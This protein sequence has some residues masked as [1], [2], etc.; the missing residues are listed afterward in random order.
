MGSISSSLDVIDF[1]LDAIGE[2][3]D[4]FWKDLSFSE[5]VSDWKLLRFIWES[6]RKLGDEPPAEQVLSM[7]LKIEAAARE[8]ARDAVLVD[9]SSS[10]STDEMKLCGSDS[11]LLYECYKKT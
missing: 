9:S 3:H 1:F 10:S 11:K 6:I 8:L 5:R 2:R 4:F 7:G